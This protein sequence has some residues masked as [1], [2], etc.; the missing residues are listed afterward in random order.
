MRFFTTMSPVLLLMIASIPPIKSDLKT[1]TIN[2]RTKNKFMARVGV[3]VEPW[4]LKKAVNMCVKFVCN[5]PDRKIWYEEMMQDPPSQGEQVILKLAKVA[6]KM[7][8]AQPHS[9]S[10]K[11][12]DEKPK[13]VFLVKS[14]GVLQGLRELL[15]LFIKNNIEITDQPVAKRGRSGKAE[16]LLSKAVV[17]A[18]PS[19]RK[20]KQEEAEKRTLNPNWVA[21]ELLEKV[22]G[23]IAA[24][25]HTYDWLTKMDVAW[26]DMNAQVPSLAKREG[27]TIVPRILSAHEFNRTDVPNLT[28]FVDNEADWY[29]AD[30][31]TPENMPNHHDRDV[32]ISGLV[33]KTISFAQ[34]DPGKILE[35]NSVHGSS[36]HGSSAQSAKDGESLLEVPAALGVSA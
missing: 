2:S 22:L 3:T 36:V 19:Q 13:V 17:A 34:E 9:D 16:A 32:A 18:L 26:L 28:V 11:I 31:V 20:K 21:E 24:M 10:P 15:K 29:R 6:V 27:E 1:A 14:Y 12:V 8:D 4:D 30:E 7:W 33:R 23:R 25:K 35:E 5:A